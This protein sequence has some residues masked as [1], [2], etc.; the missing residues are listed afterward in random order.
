MLGAKQ[1]LIEKLNGLGTE[2]QQEK[3]KDR[4]LVEKEYSY[5]WYIIFGILY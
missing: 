2:E 4:I 3:W 1:M 5:H